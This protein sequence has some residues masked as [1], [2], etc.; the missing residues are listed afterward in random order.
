MGLS[1]RSLKQTEM[2]T[3]RYLETSKNN[4]DLIAQHQKRT[5]GIIRCR[6]PPEPNGYLH[7][8]HAKSMYLNFKGAFDRLGQYD[9]YEVH[10][11]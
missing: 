7:I 8:G 4:P 10:Y 6:F 3:R 1:K 5:G 11:M 2:K 9:L